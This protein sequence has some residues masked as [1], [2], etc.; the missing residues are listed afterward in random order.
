MLSLHVRC[1]LLSC[2]CFPSEC[3]VSVRLG[4][5]QLSNCQIVWL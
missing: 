4:A 5:I 3:V 1:W 2:S